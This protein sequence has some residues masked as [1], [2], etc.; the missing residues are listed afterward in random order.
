MTDPRTCPRCGIYYHE[1]LGEPGTEA[2][3]PN[4]HECPEPFSYEV[5][6]SLLDFHVTSG[7]PTSQ[8]IKAR[9]RLGLEQGR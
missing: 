4:L 3:I 5:A 8:T 7:I 9:I 6:R 1:W 2:L